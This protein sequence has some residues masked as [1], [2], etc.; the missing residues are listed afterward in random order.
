[1]FA[2]TVRMQLKPESADA[3]AQLMENEVIPLLRKQDGFE[4]EIAF[5]RP[6]GTTAMGISL[7]ENKSNADDFQREVYPQ[8]LMALSKVIEGTPRV[9]SFEVTNSTWHKVA[10]R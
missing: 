6:G 9:R 3:F 5:V 7:W 10:A 1:M 8:V 4:D 2:R